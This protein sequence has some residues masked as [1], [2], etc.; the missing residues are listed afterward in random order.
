MKGTGNSK[1][2]FKLLSFFTLA[3]VFIY[4]IQFDKVESRVLPRMRSNK[5][6][7]M[8]E[9]LQRILERLD[10]N[11]FDGNYQNQGRM[12]SED[13]TETALEKLFDKETIKTPTKRRFLKS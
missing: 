5:N 4:C 8:Y 6:I 9:M 3:I 13:S 2:N 7:E 11:E 10:S 12:S 1:M